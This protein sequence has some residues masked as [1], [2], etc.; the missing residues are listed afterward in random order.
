MRSYKVKGPFKYEVTKG[1]RSQKVKGPY[2][3][4]DHKR[5]KV[6]TIIEV[7][8]VKGMKIHNVKSKTGIKCGY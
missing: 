8:K 5:C 4:T 1:E 2:S 7:T 3:Y 6:S